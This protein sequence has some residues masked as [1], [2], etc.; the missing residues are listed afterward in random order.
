VD[1]PGA[2]LLIDGGDVTITDSNITEN[3]TTAGFDGGG[4]YQLAGTL[5][6]SGTTIAENMAAGDGGG[7][8][9]S[10]VTLIVDASTIRSNVASGAEGSGGGLYLDAGTLSVSDSSITENRA[11]RAGGGIEVVAGT[12]TTLT[13]VDFLRN[14]AGVLPAVANPGNGGALHVTGNANVTIVGGVVIGNAAREERS[15]QRGRDAQHLAKRDHS[16]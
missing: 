10:V 7:L 9:A 14:N 5:S 6:I 3:M 13:N 1:G 2:G 12:T 4:I 11:N 8:F 15:F 16:K